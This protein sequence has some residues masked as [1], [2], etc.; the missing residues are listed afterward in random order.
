MNKGKV[1][2]FSPKKGFGLLEQKDGP[3][4][5]VHFLAIQ[6]DNFETLKAGDQ[7][8]FDIEEETRGPEAR[9]VIKL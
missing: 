5:F 8:H 2:Y 3:D 7:V 1:K 6:S 4:V 9:N